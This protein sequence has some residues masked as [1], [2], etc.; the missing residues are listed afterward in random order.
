MFLNKEIYKIY[1][2]GKRGFY[3]PEK[4]YNEV[5]FLLKTMKKFRN[6]GDENINPDPAAFIY[7]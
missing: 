2:T 4:H 1:Y 3:C 5:I 7:F 6:C